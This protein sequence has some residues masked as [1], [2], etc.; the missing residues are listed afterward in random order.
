MLSADFAVSSPASPPVPWSVIN[1]HR[2]RAAMHTHVSICSQI[3][4]AAL[5]IVLAFF[6]MPVNESAEMPIMRVSSS[7]AFT[8]KL[9]AH[10]AACGLLGC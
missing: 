1:A 9:G 3:V 8:W 5:V 2:L 6:F 7:T 10:G 4:M